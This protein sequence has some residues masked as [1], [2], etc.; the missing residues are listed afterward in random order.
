[1]LGTGCDF[2]LGRVCEAENMRCG[3]EWPFIALYQEDPDI[4]RYRNMQDAALVR[5]ARCMSSLCHGDVARLTGGI[6]RTF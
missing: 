3:N 1:M 2:G 5:I 4:G 6:R